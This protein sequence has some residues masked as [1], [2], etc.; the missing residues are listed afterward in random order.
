MECL[1]VVW[2]IGKL[3]YYLLGK[4]FEVVTDHSALQ[5]L[6]RMKEPHGM[7]ARWIAALQEY[8]F[9]VKYRKGTANSNVDALSRAPIGTQGRVYQ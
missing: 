5:W 9:I 3:R 8:N 6:F 7:Y 1:A 2:A 4:P